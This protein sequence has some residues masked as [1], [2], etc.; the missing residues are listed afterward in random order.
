[1]EKITHKKNFRHWIQAA[2]FALTNGYAQGYIQGKIYRGNNKK[3][4]VPGLNCYSCP[5]ALN[6]CP[7]GSLQAVLNSRQ[8]TVSCYVFG[9][10]MAV[11]A[12]MGRFVCGWLC[13]F[14]LVQDLLYKI[15]IFKKIKNL[16]GHKYLKK[17]KY[18]ILVLF[19]FLLSS[20][21]KDVTGL[22]QPWFC[23]YICPSG[24]LF[25]GVPLVILNPNLQAAIGGR[26]FWKL[27]LLI[28]LLILSVKAY[29]PFCKYLC[30]LGALYGL[31]NPISLYRYKVDSDAC[32]KCGACQKA[33]N[34]DIKVWETPNS[35][36]CIRCGNCKT[37][38]PQHAITS[39][40]EH[41]GRKFKENCV[42]KPQYEGENKN[43][44]TKNIIA[45]TIFM[46]LN[47][48]CLLIMTY[49]LLAYILSDIMFLG[50]TIVAAIF[51][52]MPYILGLI[53][54]IGVLCADVFY[55]SSKQDGIGSL[56]AYW[57]QK[58]CVILLG[59]AVLIALLSM[60]PYFMVYGSESLIVNLVI[61][62]A[63]RLLSGKD[64]KKTDINLD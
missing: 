48:F 61:L 38:C 29:R 64:W 12:F 5:G 31:C 7:I 13:P 56:K 22:G 16:P 37:A 19:V 15:P 35:M 60:E 3:I 36:E 41:V 23:E 43:S 6:A 44:S 10:I 32:I 39:T 54:L 49:I 45:G 57:M 62:I 21:V 1:M 2:F 25:A 40:F 46:L 58:H 14:G 18:V 28:F 24:T 30:P 42:K 51:K 53:A 50:N 59:I 26:F 34:M 8:F 17:L 52:F 63:M 47:S 33:C 27:F 9:F 4:C 20:I 11:G 55:I